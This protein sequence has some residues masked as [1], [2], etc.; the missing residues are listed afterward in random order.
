[1]VARSEFGELLVAGSC[2]QVA[3]GWALLPLAAGSCYY[4]NEPCETGDGR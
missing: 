3:D 4:P 2:G 1:M